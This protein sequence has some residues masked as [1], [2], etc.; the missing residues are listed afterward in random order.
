MSRKQKRQQSKTVSALRKVMERILL[1]LLVVVCIGA[2]YLAVILAEVPAD[3][4]APAQSPVPQVTLTAEQPRQ[5]GTLNDLKQLVEHFP[6]PV[7]ALTANTEL[8][9]AGGV[10]NDLAYK[11][12][13]ARLV[14]LTYQTQN[15][16]T[17]KLYSIYP[18]DA[19]TLL[20]GEGYTLQD[21]LTASLAGMTAVRMENADTVRLHVKGE[22]ALYAFTAPKMEE[23]LL[24]AI[25]RQAILV[26]P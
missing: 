14:T 22:S 6:S 9:F 23:E 19:F 21:K 16:E 7:L 26:K 18:L 3:Q 12:S 2:F 11:G 5:I 8:V 13:F 20:P 4:G 15:G 1:A 10:V 24:A 17:L 25:S